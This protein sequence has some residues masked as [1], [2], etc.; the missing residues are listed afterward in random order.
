MTRR[1]FIMAF[2]AI[3]IPALYL[4]WVNSCAHSPSRPIEG[5]LSILQGVTHFNRA[6]FSVLVPK[7]SQFKYRVVSQAAE[8]QPFEVVSSRFSY[9]ES[10]WAVDKLTAKGLELGQNYWLKVVNADDKVVDQR[11]FSPMSLDGDQAKIAV[12]SCADDSFQKEQ[13]IMW[14]QIWAAKP[15][16][17]F[18]IGDNVYADKKLGHK[19]PAKPTDIWKRYVETRRTLEA[20]KKE[21]LIPTLAIW[22]DHDYGANNGDR[23]YPYKTE[24]AQIFRV[25]F[26]QDEVDNVLEKGPGTSFFFTAFQQGFI[27][28]DNRS[29]RSPNGEKSPDQTHWGAL[30]E[31]WLLSKLN[32]SNRPVWIINGDQIFGGYHDFESYEGNHPSSFKQMMRALSKKA[33]PV[34]FL[35]GD[36]HLAEIMKIEP[37]VL[38][39]TTYEFTTSGV[40]A[41]VYPSSWDK[42]PNSRQIFGLAQKHNYMLFDTKRIGRGLEI[43]AR[44]VSAGPKVEFEKELILQK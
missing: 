39:Y 12:A 37:K 19:G 42:K 38:G 25:F 13:K 9:D 23:D 22:D 44:V 16:M 26:A 33:S 27:F 3:L 8:S 30:Q 11:Q 21:T 32:Y 41:N 15:Q 34:V 28:L 7:S 36:R 31:R 17:L 2:F 24:S 29:F 35:T 5:Q 10:E 14:S 6:E 20:F 18:L 40:H 4:P 43:K 1:H